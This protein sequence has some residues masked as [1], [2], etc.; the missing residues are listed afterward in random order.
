MRAALFVVAIAVLAGCALKSPPTHTDVVEQAL[1]QTTRIP[2]AWRADAR[3]RRSEPNDWLKSFNDPMLEAIV[4]EAIANNLDLRVAATKVAIAQQ[5]VIV[6]GARLMPLVGAQLGGSTT[7]ERDDGTF[8]STSAFVGVAW[9]LDVWG[10][11]R[12]SAMPRR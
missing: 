11:L 9:E 10:R 8:S 7:Y 6:V 1:P 5:T 12:A 2:A 4:A 3:G